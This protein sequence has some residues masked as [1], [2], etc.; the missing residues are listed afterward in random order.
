M[1][2][3][4][5]AQMISPFQDDL[6]KARSENEEL[7]SIIT[8]KEKEIQHLHSQLNR[9]QQPQQ[10]DQEWIESF[11]AERA[12][13]HPDLRPFEWTMELVTFALKAFSDYVWE[14]YL[15]DSQKAELKLVGIYGCA[16]ISTYFD[17]C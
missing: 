9:E 2:L 10:S 1:L 12:I 14:N 4:L 11:L 7:R 3:T 13:S 16:F 5:L 6:A 17:D 8:E 15:S